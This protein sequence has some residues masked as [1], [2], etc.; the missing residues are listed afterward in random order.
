MNH[1]IFQSCRLLVFIFFK[2]SLHR[3]SKGEHLFI[4]TI[5]GINIGYPVYEFK[6]N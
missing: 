2:T 4:E 1:K 6:I 5:S 3:E